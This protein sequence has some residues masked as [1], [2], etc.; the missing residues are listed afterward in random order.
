MRAG[1]VRNS[2]ALLNDTIIKVPTMGGKDLDFTEKRW[3]NSPPKEAST[4]P[5]KGIL[6]RLSR[7][8]K[9]SIPIQLLE[10][11]RHN[12]PGDMYPPFW[13]SHKCFLSLWRLIFYPFT[14]GFVIPNKTAQITR[15]LEN[16]KP[17]TQTKLFPFCELYFYSVFK[18]S[19]KIMFAHPF[20]FWEE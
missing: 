14:F 3:G 7:A 15:A 1:R 13:W 4:L 18:W 19:Y 12:S 20:V 8:A 2:T 9:I 6:C 11:P 10:P 16:L 17:V 5:R